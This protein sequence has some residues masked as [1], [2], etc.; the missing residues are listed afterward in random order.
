MDMAVGQPGNGN[1]IVQVDGF[2]CPTELADL[3]IAPHR[4]DLTGGDRD[5]FGRGPLGIER[6]DAS[7]DECEIDH[8]HASPFFARDG[9]TRFGSP[10]IFGKFGGYGASPAPSASSRS[11]HSNSLRRSQTVSS[12]SPWTSPSSVKRA[13]IVA[14]V[15]SSVSRPS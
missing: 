14:I 6:A 11:T 5:G 12:I 9:C 13:G 4:D 7:P 10:G 15:K 2:R 3:G 8:A 1:G